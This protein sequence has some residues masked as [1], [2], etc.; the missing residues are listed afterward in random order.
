MRALLDGTFRASS[1]T[2]P[3]HYFLCIENQL[4]HVET[5]TEQAGQPEIRRFIRLAGKSRGTYPVVWAKRYQRQE[6]GPLDSC[7]QGSLMFGACTGFTPGLDLVALRHKSAEL[8]GVLVVYVLDVIDAEGT[9]LA[10]RAIPWPAA[11]PPEALAALSGTTLGGPCSRWCATCRH[12]PLLFLPWQVFGIFLRGSGHGAALRIRA[13][14]RHPVQKQHT[15]GDN[16]VAEAY[17]T[18]AA[19]PRVALQSALD[20][21]PPALC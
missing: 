20:V 3:P 14:R 12:A 11:R 4:R 1:T 15:V 6:P 17:L 9:Y 2:S 5:S 19:R 7:G 8:L 16:L 13:F 10:P 21:Y 18:V